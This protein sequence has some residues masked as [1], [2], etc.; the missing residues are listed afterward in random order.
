MVYLS[1][2]QDHKLANKDMIEHIVGLVEE[3][4][5]EIEAQR[6]AEKAAA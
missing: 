1:G 4:A 5:A 3:K 6:A 2:V